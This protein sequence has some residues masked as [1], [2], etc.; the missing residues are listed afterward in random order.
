MKEKDVKYSS[1][2]LEFWLI[3]FAMVTVNQKT[4]QSILLQN[5]IFFKIDKYNSWPLYYFPL[6]DVILNIYRTLENNKG[7][8]EVEHLNIC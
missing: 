5:L 3:G 6:L 1:K 7:L 8:G 4:F 2:C